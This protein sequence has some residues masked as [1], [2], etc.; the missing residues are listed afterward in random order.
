MEPGGVVLD[1]VAA[2]RVDAGVCLRMGL[3]GACSPGAMGGGTVDRIG[4]GGGVTRRND[5]RTWG[6]GLVGGGTEGCGVAV[7]GG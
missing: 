5:G 1:P 3:A 6:G 2:G 4:G 7:A